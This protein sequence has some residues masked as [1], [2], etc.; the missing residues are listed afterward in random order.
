MAK[1]WSKIN[2]VTDIGNCIRIMLLLNG[3]KKRITID[4]AI[5]SSIKVPLT[6]SIAFRLIHFGHKTFWNPSGNLFSF[7]HFQFCGFLL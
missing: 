2:P 7:F 3:K 5:I 4:T 6:D 1:A